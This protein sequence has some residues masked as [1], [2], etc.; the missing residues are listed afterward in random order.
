MAMLPKPY[1][2]EVI[3]SVIARG[4][5][6]LG[7]STKHFVQRCMAG[8]RSST[9][10]LMSWNAIEL[11]RMTGLDAM[12]LLD[13]HTML[14]Y[15]V[16]FMSPQEQLRLRA[17]ALSATAGVDC[18]AALT[19]NVSRGVPYRRVCLDCI[20][21][22]VKNHGETYWH[23]E[24][25]LPGVLICARHRTRLRATAIPL[26]GHTHLGGWAMPSSVGTREIG[27]LDTDDATISEI[28]TLSFRALLQT[29]VPS[30]RWLSTYRTAAIQKGY[31]MPGGDI[32]GRRLAVDLQRLFGTSLLT[33]I[34]CPIGLQFRNPWPA[35]MVREKI[36]VPFA[37][38]KHVILQTFLKLGQNCDGKFEYDNPGPKL[39]N[40]AHMD[41][42]ALRK[43][44]GFLTGTATPMRHT[45][46]ELLKAVGVWHKYRHNRARFP[47]LNE[48]L[49]EFKASNRSA[50][51][52]GGRRRN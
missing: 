47:L 45:V 30:D 26:R 9:S 51:Q 38:V 12:E 50:K 5:F 40:Y 32:A 8:A 7:W 22:E 52:T 27:S 34:G 43:A 10:F 17:K 13:N 28:A 21:A 44:Q 19:K 11:A 48:W 15:S 49:R 33:Q 39:S 35:L 31:R 1:P 14:P 36:G 41:R 46:T 2:D 3:G 18:L 16:A 42:L 37:T 24:H 29:I 23:R 20:S 25:Q 4:C 6:Q